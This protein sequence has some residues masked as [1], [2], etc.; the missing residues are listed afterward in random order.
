MN[1]LLWPNQATMAIKKSAF[2]GFCITATKYCLTE[3]PNFNLKPANSLNYPMPVTED[4]SSNTRAC[5]LV[6]TTRALTS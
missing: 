2:N 6:A 3:Q 4:G 1:N 5:G